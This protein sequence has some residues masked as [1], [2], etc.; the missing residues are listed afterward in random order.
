MFKFIVGFFVA[1]V[2]FYSGT[3]YQS[4]RFL[5]TIDVCVNVAVTQ[6]TLEDALNFYEE[7][8]LNYNHAEAYIKSEVL[9]CILEKELK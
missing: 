1:F 3:I 9:N 4:R 2:L 5:N 7:T 6:D 8:S